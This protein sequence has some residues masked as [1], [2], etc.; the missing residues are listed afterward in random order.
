MHGGLQLHLSEL[1]IK[2]QKDKKKK[3]ILTNKEDINKQNKKRHDLKSKNCGAIKAIFKDK[4]K[5]KKCFRLFLCLMPFFPLS[6]K[7]KSK[8]KFLCFFT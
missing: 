4:I 6:A 3:S 8:R 7:G 1:I 5:I 2:N